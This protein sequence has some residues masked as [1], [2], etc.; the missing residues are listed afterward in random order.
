VSRPGIL[1][2]VFSGFVSFFSCLSVKS[3]YFFSSTET[4]SVEEKKEIELTDKQENNETK[5]ENTLN[6]IPG[7]DTT[8]PHKIVYETQ[9]ARYIVKGGICKQLEKMLVSL[10]V[11]HLETGV[12]YRCRL[13]LY[14][15][16]QTRKEAVEASEKLDLRVDLVEYD[17]SIL[18][19]L[20]DEYRES[21]FKK[22]NH[23]EN[24]YKKDK[25]VPPYWQ[26]KCLKL[27]KSIDLMKD[28]RITIKQAGVIG[29]EKNITMLFL[30]AFSHKMPETLHVI[31]QGSSGSGK[32]TL[33][34]KTAG[35]MPEERVIRFTRVTEG[36]FY[37]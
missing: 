22:A 32:T 3:I 24:K 1:F 23:D 9:T 11:Q 28:L 13:D 37:N 12:K 10:D 36:S 2:S 15:E 5:P 16:K 20:L 26:E 7:L 33:L 19:D 35:F 27:L 34:S 8:N 4:F 14:E 6:K 21:L 29:E 25:P 31:I 18:T 30:C 17:L